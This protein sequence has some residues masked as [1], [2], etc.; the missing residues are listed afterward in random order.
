MIDYVTQHCET[1][2]AGALWS[3]W[4]LLGSRGKQ[5]ET[6]V[7]FFFLLCFVFPD[8]AN[9]FSMIHDAMSFSSAKNKTI[10]RNL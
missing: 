2:D 6:I 3:I 7:S 8:F 9:H 1:I 5:K 4:I 10:Q